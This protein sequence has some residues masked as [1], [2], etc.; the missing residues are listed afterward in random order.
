MLDREYWTKKLREAEAELEAAKK[1][2]DVKAAASRLQRAKAEL[3]ELEAEQLKRPRAD[4]RRDRTP[5]PC[6]LTLSRANH[7]AQWCAAESRSRGL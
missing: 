6:P 7:R 3:K 1:P 2:S 4:R 5:R